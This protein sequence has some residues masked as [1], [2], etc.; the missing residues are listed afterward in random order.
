[1]TIAE[2]LALIGI[3]IPDNNQK[4][5]KAKDVRDSFQ[6]IGEE[7][8]TKADVDAE[9]I[10]PQLAQNWRTKIE[11]Q[12]SIQEP[13]LNGNILTIYYTGENGVQQTQNVDLSGLATIDI[14]IE[15]AE[16]DAA[17]NI[18]TITQSDGSTF[19]ID[20]SEFSIISTTNPDGSV[21]LVQEAVEKVKI[22]KVGI[23]GSYND[24]TDKPTFTEVDTLATVVNRNNY[25][26]KPITF[27]TGGGQETF[28]Q[29][30][31]NPTTYSFFWGNMNPAHTGIYNHSY[32]YGALEKVT[33]GNNN[34]AFGAFASKEL[35]TGK[36]NTVVGIVAAQNATTGNANVIM[37]EEAANKI[38][39][40]YKNTI[41]G[42][43]AAYFNT[44]GNL[45]TLIGY[46]ANNTAVLG[47]RNIIIGPFSGQGVTGTNNVLLGVCAGMGDGAI[48]NKLIIHSNNTLSG[49]GN[50]PT[51]EGAVGSPQQGM[52]SRGLITGDFVDRWVRINGYM[53]VGSPGVS[54]SDI[55][56]DPSN[57]IKG[58]KVYT[59]ASDYDYIQKGWLPNNYIPLS[60]T[61]VGKP[62]T[63]DIEFS[64]GAPATLKS[65][66]TWVTIN[67]GTFDVS[68]GSSISATD[69]SWF[70]V[71]QNEIYLGKQ[72]SNTPG[73]HITISNSINYIDIG[74]EYDGPGLVGASYYGANYTDNSFVQKIWV[75]ETIQKNLRPYKAYVCLL[76]AGGT[77]TPSPSFIE[78]ENTI[79]AIVWTR[80]NVGEYIGTLNGAFPMDKVVCFA[81]C[82][83]GNGGIGANL[84]ILTARLTDDSIFVKVTRN[85][86]AATPFEVNGQFG[87]LEVRV[88]N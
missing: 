41:V 38:T 48:N 2:I 10:T 37:G 82:A 67:N 71:S 57:G 14:S 86:E 19:Q 83:Q 49:Y 60:G 24:L 70:V 65:G 31:V 39:T 80:S 54:K 42:T 52:L 12:T 87:S 27:L 30:G 55:I 34:L 66:N 50:D 47:D 23:S 62:V 5:I 64:T 21:S 84:N 17:Q 56:I 7:I 69:K 32:G 26:P 29:I 58:V 72:N 75:E 61:V 11:T 13:Q 20:L 73:K 45:N 18:I 33:T 9:N 40:G 59:P 6:L 4:K 68:S 16:Y 78:L 3:K 15:N 25:S 28:G 74:A 77:P 53:V 85:D 35:T 36:L 76:Q 63:G 43:A 8:D 44:T 51:Q 22:H 1:M 88:Y 81:Q 46:K 79:G